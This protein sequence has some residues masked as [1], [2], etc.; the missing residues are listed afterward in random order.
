MPVKI[1]IHVDGYFGLVKGVPRLLKLFEQ[2]KIKATFFV[3]MG[4]EASILN[5]LKYLRKNKEELKKTKRIIKRYNQLEMLST[6][7]LMRKIGCGH[8]NLLKEIEKRGH[9]VEPHCWSHLEWSKN[10]E[11]FDYKKQIYLLKKSFKEC[12]GRE[13]QSFA[14]P[15]W[16]VNAE[17]LKELAR[18]GFKEVCI[19]KKD[20]EKFK[21]FKEI[22][23]NVLTFDKTIEELLAEGKNEKEIIE[24]YKREKKKK[25]AHL[26]FH[27]DFEGRRGMKLFMKICEA[28]Q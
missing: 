5:L 18:Q 15:T 11:N 27:A 1:S 25:G 2:N 14:P 8:Q 16:K 10:F 17:I 24:I 23:F 13:P 26:Y 12:L 21:H 4:R 3:N 20:I 7:F 28:L 9:R 22:K 6:V 19:L